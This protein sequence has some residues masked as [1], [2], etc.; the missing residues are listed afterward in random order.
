MRRFWALRTSGRLIVTLVTPPSND[1]VR[2]VS[3]MSPTVGLCEDAG[4]ERIVVGVDGSS[5]A[6]AALR[7]SVEEAEHH[8]ATV[9][10]LLAWNAP[11]QEQGR[12]GEV[13]QRGYDDDDAL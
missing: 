10:A 11:E 2:I 8:G 4:M 6:E 3:Y 13:R 12:P 9:V 1:S 5:G 7:W